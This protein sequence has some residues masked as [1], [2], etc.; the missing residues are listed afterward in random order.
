MSIDINTQVSSSLSSLEQEFNAIAHNLANVNTVGYKRITTSFAKSL[1]DK[2]RGPSGADTTK[3]EINLGVDFSQG[4]SLKET[5][6]TLDVALCDKG[7]FVIESPEFQMYTRNGSF[8]INQNGQIVDSVGRIVSGEGGPITVNGDTAVSQINIS[9]DG[10]ISANGQELGKFRIVDFPEAQDKI[11]PVGG[12]C[13]RV[14]EDVDPEIV[15]NVVCRQGYLESSNVKM[16]DEL[17]GMIM[18]QRLYEA[19]MKSLSAKREASSNLM[20]VA[21]G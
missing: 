8:R 17:V 2:Q 16:V 7:F 12:S 18:V 21:M 4:L 19:N 1:E 5:G 13:F 11:I 6:R 9:S 15:E 10:T 14:P 20:S 3:A